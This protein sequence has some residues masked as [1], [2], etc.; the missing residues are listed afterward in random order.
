MAIQQGIALP[1]CSETTAGLTL[2]QGFQAGAQQRAC[3]DLHSR[4]TATP[5]SA[6]EG[7]GVG[8]MV[9]PW[10]KLT[11]LVPIGREM[12]HASRLKLAARQMSNG[13]GDGHL[14]HT[15]PWSPNEVGWPDASTPTDVD[16]DV[17]SVVDGQIAW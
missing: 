3:V 15:T 16:E 1:A 13:D 5:G 11:C 7:V 12:P 8:R 2:S 10:P 6:G 17:C 14:H 9:G 4:G